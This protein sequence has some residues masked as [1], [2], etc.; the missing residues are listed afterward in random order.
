MCKQPSVAHQSSPY[1][2]GKSSSVMV[3]PFAGDD[4][5]E[6]VD[7]HQNPLLAGFRGAATFRHHNTRSSIIVA[8]F[9][10]GFVDPRAGKEADAVIL[11]LHGDALPHGTQPTNVPLVRGPCFDA[12]VDP[13]VDMCGEVVGDDPFETR[14]G[15]LRGVAV[16][17]HQSSQS[18]AYRSYCEPSS[19]VSGPRAV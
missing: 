3:G 4:R 19:G 13:I 11:R 9:N 7:G 17:R 12:A 14:P 6:I 10:V 1:G 16:A 8:H 2:N 18:N 15:L 5:N